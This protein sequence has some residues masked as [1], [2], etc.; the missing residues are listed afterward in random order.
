MATGGQGWFDLGRPLSQDDKGHFPTDATLSLEG[1]L[2]DN[3][4][5]RAETEPLPLCDDVGTPE[6]PPAG[7]QAPPLSQQSM[8]LFSSQEARVQPSPGGMPEHPVLRSQ[9][10]SQRSQGAMDEPQASWVTSQG[11]SQEA[12]VEVCPHPSNPHYSGL[13]RTA[14]AR[15]P[16]ADMNLYASD[17]AGK[18]EQTVSKL[19]KKGRRGRKVKEL[20]GKHLD[21][22]KVIIK[23]KKQPESAAKAGGDE[24]PPRARRRLEVTFGVANELTK[25]TQKQLALGFRESV[26]PLRK[27][28]RVDVR[29]PV[30]A[31]AV[32]E[33]EPAFVPHALRGGQVGPM[34]G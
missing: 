29:G 33:E 6:L 20:E 2:Q 10:L 14:E 23:R 19:Q 16:I 31:G 8:Q 28:L 11:L 34:D 1:Y 26:G 17:A 9:E 32:K 15:V 25:A 18:F 21:L 5:P 4:G 12:V 13:D 22:Q 7:S 30:A 24:E 3:L 27:H